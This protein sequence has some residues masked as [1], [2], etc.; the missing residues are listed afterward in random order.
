MRRHLN[1]A[2]QRHL[3]VLGG[4]ARIAAAGLTNVDARVMDGQALALPDGV[5]QRFHL[6]H[7]VVCGSDALK[8]DVVF[9]GESV[10]KPLVDE[11]FDLVDAAG[12]VNG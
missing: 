5:V 4:L 7:C 12:A 1:G 3:K 11:C 6:A 10:P 8:P 2:L 9:F